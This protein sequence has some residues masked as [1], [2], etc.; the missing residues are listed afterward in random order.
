MDATP[1]EDK[2]LQKLVLS[3]PKVMMGLLKSLIASQ[4]LVVRG[5]KE[6]LR[7]IVERSR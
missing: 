5:R 2:V 3:K 4:R 6:N 7:K 1:A